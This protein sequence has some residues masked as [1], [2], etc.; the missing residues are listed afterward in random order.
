[1]VFALEGCFLDEALFDTE[2][3]DKIKVFARV[4]PENKTL[5]VKNIQLALQKEY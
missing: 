5:I 2:T 1:M 4:S 3:I